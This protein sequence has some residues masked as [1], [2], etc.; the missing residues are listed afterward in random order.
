MITRLNRRDFFKLTGV[1]VSGLMLAMSPLSVL[2]KNATAKLKPNA[3]LLIDALNQVTFWAPRPELG[4]GTKTGLATVIA[5]ELDYNVELINI[6]QANTQPEFGFIGVGGSYGLQGAYTR[7]RETAARAKLMIMQAAAAQWK[8]PLSEL[9]T[10]NGHVIHINKGKKSPYGTFVTEASKLPVP[11]EVSLKSPDQFSQIGTST[12]RYDN[13]DIIQGKAAFGLDI[14]FP[15]M[16]YASIERS[17]TPRGK[18]QEYNKEQLTNTHAVSQII[19]MEGTGFPHENHM[20]EGIAILANSHWEALKARQALQVT[21][22]APE[23]PLNQTQLEERLNHAVST[24]GNTVLAKGD[25]TLAQSNADH[26]LEATYHLPFLAHSPMETP[27]ATAV[28]TEK[29]CKIWCGIQ[30][31]TRLQQRL[32]SVLGLNKEQITIYPQLCGGSFGRRLEI[33][34]AVEAAILSQK[35]GKPVQLLWTRE[36]DIQFGQYRTTSLHKMQAAIKDD[37]LVGFSE[38]S[39]ILSVAQQQGSKDAFK[40]GVDT[41]YEDASAFPYGI[42]HLDFQQ[43]IVAADVPVAW[44][45]GVS[46]TNYSVSYECWIDEL[47]HHLKKDPLDYRI[48][49]LNK[50]MQLNTNDQK[51]TRLLERS[52]RVLE[53]VAKLT[54]WQEKSANRAEEKT[55]GRGVAYFNFGG[56]SPTA[57]VIESAVDSNNQIKIIKVTSVVDC[58]I[59]VNPDLI[60]AQFEGGTIFGLSSVFHQ[61]ITINAGAIQ[62]TNFHDYASCRMPETPAIETH[63]LASTDNPEGVGEP[64]L[65]TIAP[66]VLNSI[67]AATGKRFRSL[68]IKYQL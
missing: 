64:S 58:G 27:N 53:E 13:Q 30:S 24:P 9:S 36:D 63:I 43:N 41:Y 20:R 16:L 1:S 21:W 57:T 49:L 31:A 19:E 4:Q 44:W 59:A 14:K 45:R 26:A 37:E 54:H 60:K 23:E 5:E 2:G 7:M 52:I 10:E 67:F 32:T 38:N 18:I 40:D 28:V 12:K 46:A 61:Q 34:Y 22:K 68:P 66:A 55:K 25:F 33:E 17:P 65:M 47:A 11:E 42:D 6:E 51:R 56:R 35:T 50:A 8:V 29:S 15:G 39:A 3:F 48:Q 62:Q